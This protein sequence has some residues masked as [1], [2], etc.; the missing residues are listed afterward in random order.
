MNEK[1]ETKE[2]S[3][4]P[5]SSYISEAALD[6][7]CYL[8]GHHDGK[9][10][11][12][13]DPF[14]TTYYGIRQSG[15]DEFK[16]LTKAGWFGNEVP[17]ELTA[18]TLD[19]LTEEQAREITGYLAMANTRKMDS[20]YGDNSCQYISALP[21]DVRSAILTLAH[22]RG[23]DKMIQNY[24]NN[25]NDP[26]SILRAAR[27]GE[28]EAIGMSILT[29]PDG[30]LCNSPAKSKKPGNVNRHMAAVRLMYDT[31]NESFKDEDSKDKTYSEWKN[32]EN[33]VK[34]WANLMTL[35][36]DGNLAKADDKEKENFYCYAINNGA[37]INKEKSDISNAPIAPQEGFKQSTNV[38][39]SQQQKNEDEGAL[40]K[41]TN[42][43]KKLFT[44]K[45]ETTNAAQRNKNID[46]Q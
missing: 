22:N 28:R 27:T 5:Y 29:M 41:L 32:D 15:L 37:R 14:E 34:K 12:K 8:E 24:K 20:A 16:R 11:P 3:V 17:K 10:K 30:T 26:S 31:D 39:T 7:I 42:G 43:M 2:K 40:A 25:P 21:I 44:N 1:T 13:G 46:M 33:I 6:A 18:S 36:H 35:I 9:K 45:E 38:S 4:K 23:V 19:S